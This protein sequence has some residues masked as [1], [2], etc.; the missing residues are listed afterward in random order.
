MKANLPKDKTKKSPR[1]WDR[2]PEDEKKAITDYCTKVVTEQVTHEEAELQKRW[3]QL[4]CIVLHNQKDRFGKTRC[5][6]FLAGWKRMYRICNR[7]KTNAEIDA[8]LEKEMSAIFGEGG[9]PREWVD[10]LE[11]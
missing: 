5:M 11:Q 7:F 3:I 6:A 9:Y 2:L 8:F 10:S 1:S 4:A